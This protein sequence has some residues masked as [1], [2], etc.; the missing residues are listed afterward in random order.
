MRPGYPHVRHG[1]VHFEKLQAMRGK[2]LRA[3]GYE[4]LHIPT[5]RKRRAVRTSRREQKPSV[6]TAQL[7]EMRPV[8]RLLRRT[9]DDLIKRVRTPQVTA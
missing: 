9:T 2:L 7:A 8:T 4:P 3:L 6:R 5:L 1:F